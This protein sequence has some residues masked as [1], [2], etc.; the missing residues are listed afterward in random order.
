MK[1]TVKINSRAVGEYLRSAS[2]EAEMLRMA[3]AIAKAA[4][5][6]YEASGFVGKRARASVATVTPR[7]I[8]DNQKNQTLL[9]ALNAG[10]RA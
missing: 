10:R 5:A 6:G 8:R 7:A 2:V 9:R 3:R 4:G 1:A